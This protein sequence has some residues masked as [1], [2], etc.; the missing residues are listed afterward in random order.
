MFCDVFVLLGC[1]D[2]LLVRT[3]TASRSVVAFGPRGDRGR[4]LIL[5]L[6]MEKFD[7]SLRTTFSGEKQL[8]AVLQVKHSV[9]T[10]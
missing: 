3:S 5:N 2:S 7:L 6:I 10:V 8:R 1:F 9:F 4:D